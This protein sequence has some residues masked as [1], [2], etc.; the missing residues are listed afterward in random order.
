VSGARPAPPGQTI[1]P[2][3]ESTVTVEPSH[4]R[5]AA[6]DHLEVVDANDRLAG[7]VRAWKA[8]S[9][10]VVSRSRRND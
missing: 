7:G 5:A 6:L 10:V 4:V 8:E 9:V 3:S 1:V 2:S